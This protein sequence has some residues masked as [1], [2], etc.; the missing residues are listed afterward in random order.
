MSYS[1]DAPM[2]E[3]LNRIV[4]IALEALTEDVTN[5]PN[6]LRVALSQIEDVAKVPDWP[7]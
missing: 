6:L 2:R 1:H 7:I 3:R 5:K 4:E